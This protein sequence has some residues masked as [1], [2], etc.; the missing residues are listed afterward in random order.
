MEER[1]ANADWHRISTC[2]TKSGSFPEKFG[3]ADARLPA[4][5]RRFLDAA[6]PV[7]T[8]DDYPN[9]SGLRQNL[10]NESSAAPIPRFSPQN[11]LAS[12]QIWGRIVAIALRQ[13]LSRYAF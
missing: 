2:A 9:P 11:R 12:G 4:F 5:L 3:Y 6:F 7:L 1:C 10:R 8:P 13:K